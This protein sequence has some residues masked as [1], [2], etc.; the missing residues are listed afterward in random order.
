[1]ALSQRPS[2]RRKPVFSEQLPPVGLAEQDAG[3]DKSHGRPEG[4]ADD[5]PKAEVSPKRGT[6]RNQIVKQ[7]NLTRFPVAQAMVPE[8]EG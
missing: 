7:I 4:W 2:F 3:D 1:M 6:Q 8:R 5:F